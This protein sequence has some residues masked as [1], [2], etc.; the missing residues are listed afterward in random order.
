VSQFSAAHPLI[1]CRGWHRLNG[2]GQLLFRGPGAR[3]QFR[4]R[5]EALTLFLGADGVHFDLLLNGVKQGGVG[6]A[7]FRVQD[8]ACP[9]FALPA[10]Q[11]VDVEL[12]Q[13][14]ESAERDIALYGMLLQQ[15]SLLPHDDGGRR[16][17]IEF[18]GDSYFVGY[19]N[20]LGAAAAQRDGLAAQQVAALT[21][22]Q[23]G[24]AALC[25][26]QLG[27][28]WRIS[29]VSGR[30]MVRNYA[31]GDTARLP[32]IHR[33]TTAAAAAPFRADI[34][35]INLG[36]NDFST[37]LHGVYREPFASQDALVSAYRRGYRD[38]FHYLGELYG[39]PQILLVGVPHP[40]SILQPQL[41][42][43]LAQELRGEFPLHYCALPPVP[44]RGCDGHPDLAGHRRCAQV[45]AE[46]LKPLCE[47]AAPAQ[48]A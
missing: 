41:L 24:M 6:A 22:S 35:V 46:A 2:A 36:T 48:R 18:I 38:F 8:R 1:H 3:L 37:P 16:P 27:A 14:S 15:G 44:L 33:A 45:L 25:G 13:R 30:G 10:A 23:R 29:A 11:P 34:A 26:E 19:G 28:N 42:Q 12:R 31:G 21:D 4:C 32:E 7:S 9:R 17:R 20:L 39:R 43:A 47:F 40:Q 5:G